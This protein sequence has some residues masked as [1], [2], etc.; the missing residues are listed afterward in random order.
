MKVK[1]LNTMLFGA[2]LA[3]CS[4]EEVISLEMGDTFLKDGIG[5]VVIDNSQKNQAV[6]AVSCGGG[7]AMWSSPQ[8]SSM[9][10]RPIRWK[11]LVCRLI[12]L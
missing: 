11:A 7:E 1:F 8:R 10:E 12:S 6:E 3:S 2:C 9:E 4:S 5:Y